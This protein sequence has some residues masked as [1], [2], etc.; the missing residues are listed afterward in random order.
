M[1]CSSSH[2]APMST[3][4]PCL[5]IGGGIACEVRLIWRL[6]KIV[7]KFCPTPSAP[8]IALVFGLCRGLLCVS[9]SERFVQRMAFFGNRW[10]LGAKGDQASRCVGEWMSW[11]MRDFGRRGNV[12]CGV[13]QVVW[14]LPMG[15]LL[16]PRGVGRISRQCVALGTVRSCGT[17][18]FVWISDSLIPG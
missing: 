3:M 4:V 17:S 1:L 15:L 6:C 16:H 7:T 12:V 10:H 2:V 18:L 13:P 11:K 8:H 5:R 14:S 9:R